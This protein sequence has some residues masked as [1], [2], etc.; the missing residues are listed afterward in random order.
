[1]HDAIKSIATVDYRPRIGVD[2]GNAGEVSPRRRGSEEKG[3]QRRDSEANAFPGPILRAFGAFGNC[4]TSP[5]AGIHR[6]LWI[7][8]A[9]EPSIRYL[10]NRKAQ[11]KHLL[12][13]TTRPH[14]PLS[15]LPQS[16]TDSSPRRELFLIF[17]SVCR[18]AGYSGRECLLRA[19]CETSEFPLRHNGLIGDIMHV[20]FT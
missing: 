8:Y 17:L 11:S 3:N 9:R 18:S 6:C 5:D 2:R 20:I 13:P 7:T 10:E 1:M 15:F 19:I 16:P 12:P 4:V 14:N